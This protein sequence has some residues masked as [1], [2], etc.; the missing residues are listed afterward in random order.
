MVRFAQKEVVHSDR[1]GLDSEGG[2]LHSMGDLVPWK[3]CLLFYRV[4][5]FSEEVRL[6]S[7]SEV[8]RGWW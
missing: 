4:A 3:E 6:E 8:P 1:A 2:I 7:T 5:S